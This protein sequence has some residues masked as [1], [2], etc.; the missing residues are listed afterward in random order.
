MTIE[1]F[2]RQFQVG[3]KERELVKLGWE[4]EP[5]QTMFHIVNAYT[6]AAQFQGLSAEASFRLMKV[7]GLVLAMV[8]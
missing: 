5:G 8:K 1:S 4:Q 7:G 6:R 2:N 3:E